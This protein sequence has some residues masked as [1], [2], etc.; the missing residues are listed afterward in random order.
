MFTILTYNNV[1]FRY[2]SKSWNYTFD[3]IEELSLVKK[4]KSYSKENFAFI[5]VTA[6][7]YYFMLFSNLMDLYYI[8]PAIL[9]YSVI[10]TLR[11]HDTS[12]FEFY[13]FVKD[14]YNKE[15]II[16]IKTTDRT[17]IGKHIDLY[18]DLKFKKLVSQEI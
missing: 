4:N 12:K 6:L 13:V 7:A 14:I 10:I 16:K 3:E 1:Q 2:G 17:K 9:C 5:S 8:I 11:F 15:T 18:L